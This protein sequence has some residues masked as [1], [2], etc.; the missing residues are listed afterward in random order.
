M[1]D[2]S[3]SIEA[4]DRASR[5]RLLRYCA[6]PP[7]AL[8]RLR[9]LD[10]ERLPYE[11]NKPGPGGNAAHPP[12]PLLRH[13]GVLAQTAAHEKFRREAERQELGRMLPFVRQALH[14]PTRMVDSL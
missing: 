7:C 4:V 13:F 11:S 1:L 3:V 2:G 9:E 14:D 10:P 6:P 12:R 8:D 5:E